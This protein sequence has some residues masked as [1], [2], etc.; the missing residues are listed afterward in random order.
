MSTLKLRVV[1]EVYLDHKKRQP[2]DLVEV[3]RAD[4]LN[5]FGEFEIPRWAVRY[6]D[7][8]LPGRNQHREHAPFGI[9]A[10]PRGKAKA[11]AE[12]PAELVFDDA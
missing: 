9:E 10:T 5:E 8:F 6:E 2:G 12:E 11:S 4:C 3:D 1:Q 7:K